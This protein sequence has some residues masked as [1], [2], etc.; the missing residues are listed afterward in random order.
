L[1]PLHEE[2]KKKTYTSSNRYAVLS[3]VD[4]SD[5]TVFDAAPSPSRDHTVVLQSHPTDLADLA[6][7]FYISNI[8][9]F[10][11]FNDTL[12][13]TTTPNGFTCKS[14][15][16]HLIVRHRGKNN[17]NAIAKYL[18]EANA[19]F[20]THR[21][22]CNRPFTIDIRNLHYSTL[23]TDISAALLEEGHIVKEVHN[24]RKK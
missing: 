7:P 4:I 24:I 15:P 3:T 9:N 2:K 23:S 22:R 21:A 1:S 6:P 17:F 10:S 8:T 13:K 19:S 14:T 18:M 16:S 5:D 20:H 11:A 12:I